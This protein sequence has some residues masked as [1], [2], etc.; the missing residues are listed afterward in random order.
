MLLQVLQSVHYQMVVFGVVQ[1]EA[2]LI[3]QVLHPI[4]M[5]PKTVH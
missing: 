1:V 3:D 5:F 2:N 4:M